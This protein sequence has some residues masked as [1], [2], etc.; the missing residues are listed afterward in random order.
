MSAVKDRP[1]R[2]IDIRK[3]IA[4]LQ[5]AAQRG[6]IGDVLIETLK[7]IERIDKKINEINAKIDRIEGRLKDIEDSLTSIEGTVT[8]VKSQVGEVQPKVDRMGNMLGALTEATLSRFILED[9][10]SEGYVI[11]GYTRNY[12]LDDY[13]IDLLVDA[14]KNGEHVMLVVSIKVK[15]KHRDVSEVLGAADLYGSKYNVKAKPM[16]AGVWV[17]SEVEA[18]ARRKGVTVVRF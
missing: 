3:R 14:T 16:L 2:G 18:Y 9:L 12:R 1:G 11:Q 8:D 6:E 4:N 7:I 13:D 10:K 15:P 17:G 5:D